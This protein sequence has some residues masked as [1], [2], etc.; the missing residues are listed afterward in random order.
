MGSG[1]AGETL[2]AS[3]NEFGDE[4]PSWRRDET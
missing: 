3:G 4:D 1:E 2:P